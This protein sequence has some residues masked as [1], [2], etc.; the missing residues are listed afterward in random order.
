ML[1]NIIRNVDNWI[2]CIKLFS[3]KKMEG[4]D[5]M[6]NAIKIKIKYTC[7]P[8]IF[9]MYAFIKAIGWYNWK[10]VIIERI[11]IINEVVIGGFTF[12][13]EIWILNMGSAIFNKFDSD[14]NNKNK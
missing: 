1:P 4:I 6:Q 12:E 9:G 5:I 3:I 7:I 2:V 10:V 14:I 13:S 8:D 11:N